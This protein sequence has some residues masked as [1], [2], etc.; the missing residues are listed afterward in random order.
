MNNNYN[1]NKSIEIF[2]KTIK[3]IMNDPLIEITI[4]NKNQLGYE[5]E[6]KLGIDKNELPIADFFGIEIKCVYERSIYPIKL[7]SSEFDGPNVME[8]KV[9]FDKYHDTKNNK[10]TFNHSFYGNKITKLSNSIYARLYV[11]KIE[12]RI[13]LLFF[14]IYNCCVDNAYWDFDTLYNHVKNKLSNLAI[15]NYKYEY[16]GDKKYY[17]ITRYKLLKLKDL[18]TFIN[19]IECGIIAISFSIEKNNNS[20]H[21]HGTSF[22]I[23][24]E[25]ITKLFDIQ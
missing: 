19:L 2:D 4:N 11:D 21:N 16:N 3:R 15:I 23:K 7:F 5:I 22:S 13:H 24:R 18:R 1:E 25:N 10:E 12:K 17:K 6:K 9:L 20:I 8:A 14:D